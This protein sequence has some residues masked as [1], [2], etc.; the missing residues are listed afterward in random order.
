[1]L[2]NNYFNFANYIFCNRFSEISSASLF[3]DDYEDADNENISN[4]ELNLYSDKRKISTTVVGTE[5]N[6]ET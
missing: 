3:V 1:M 6:D 2:I 4:D 5:P